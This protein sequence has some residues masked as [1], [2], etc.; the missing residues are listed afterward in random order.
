MLDRYGWDEKKVCELYRKSVERRSALG[1][2]K[3][4]QDIVEKDLKLEQLP[5][6][7]DIK[8]VVAIN[9]ATSLEKPPP[10]SGNAECIVDG[11][12]V[13]YGDVI[14]CYEMRHG[15]GETEG[16]EPDAMPITPDQFATYMMY[17]TQWRWLQCERYAH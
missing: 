14:G 6:A 4:K 11:K 1:L 12:Q 10:R 2:A 16:Q 15:Q 3:V 7:A 5:H 13:T 9:G 8:Q 17:V